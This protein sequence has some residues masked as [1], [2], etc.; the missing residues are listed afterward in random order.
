ME[1]FWMLDNNP[2]ALVHFAKKLSQQ[3]YYSLVGRPIRSECV[4]IDQALSN[5]D[6]RNAN[7]LFDMVNRNAMH[8]EFPTSTYVTA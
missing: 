6:T 7:T 2:D 3:L 4:D 8:I 5:Y 1:A